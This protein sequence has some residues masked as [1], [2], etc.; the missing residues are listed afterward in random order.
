MKPRGE[1][2]GRSE[3]AAAGITNP[4]PRI[5]PPC[6]EH[7]QE[8]PGQSPAAQAGSHWGGLRAAPAT[9][10]PSPPL[11]HLIS[12]ASRL[13]IICADLPL[14]WVPALPSIPTALPHFWK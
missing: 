13:P 7:S 2:S 5:Q 4:V 8:P 1:T 9:A 11:I 14:I 3:E 12:A 10:E 6:P